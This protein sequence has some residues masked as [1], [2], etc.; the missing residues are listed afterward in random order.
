MS[1]KQQ[2]PDARKHQIV[3]FVKSTIRIVGYAFIPYS[4]ETATILLILSEFVGIIEE[5]V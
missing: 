5:L 1:K 4:L 2:L 3:S